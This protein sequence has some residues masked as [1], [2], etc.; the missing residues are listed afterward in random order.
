MAKPH[1]EWTVLPHGKLKRVQHDLLSVSGTM[2]M[3]PMGY[4][5]SSERVLRRPASSLS[6]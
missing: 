4:R 1:S 3:P 5:A 6:S 2:N